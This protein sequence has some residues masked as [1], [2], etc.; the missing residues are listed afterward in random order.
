MT[1][2]EGLHTQAQYIA[3]L[4]GFRRLSDEMTEPGKSGGMLNG[5]CNWQQESRPHIETECCLPYK[6]DS[7]RSVI[8]QHFCARFENLFFRFKCSVELV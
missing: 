8:L 6:V 2:T 3:K 5:L 4:V 1:I 7:T